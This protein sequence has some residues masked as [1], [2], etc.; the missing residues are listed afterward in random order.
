MSRSFIVGAVTDADA[1]HIL[2][3]QPVGKAAIICI[4][5]VCHARRGVRDGQ[6]DLRAVCQKEGAVLRVLPQCRLDGSGLFAV[7]LSALAPGILPDDSRF[8]N[9]QLF[10][11]ANPAAHRDG[12]LR[13]NIH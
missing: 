9:L 12:K 4:Q 11:P 10:D 2:R 1:D 3:V 6:P 13:V 8:K 7:G 5:T